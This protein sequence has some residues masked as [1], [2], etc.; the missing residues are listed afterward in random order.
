MTGPTCKYSL[1]VSLHTACP[2]QI[3]PGIVKT[4]KAI[5]KYFMASEKFANSTAF[6]TNETAPYLIKP[7]CAKVRLPH[8]N[9]ELPYAC[10]ITCIYVWPLLWRLVLAVQCTDAA[11]QRCTAIVTDA[12]MAG[13]CNLSPGS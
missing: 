7:P 12:D 9:A 6:L 13:S 2:V 1:L 5:D 4:M 10:Q 3:P 11:P 8:G